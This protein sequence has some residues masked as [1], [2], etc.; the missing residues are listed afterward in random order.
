M[1]SLEE[2]IERVADAAFAQTSPVRWS[3]P[4]TPGHSAVRTDG[5]RSALLATAAVVLGLALIGG[6]LALARNDRDAP[7]TPVDSGIANV[8]AASTVEV[9]PSASAPAEP[10]TSTTDRA[11]EEA[12]STAP[13][14]PLRVVPF[15]SEVDGSV[16]FR[17]REAN[18]DSR[19][20]PL[21]DGEIVLSY[22]LQLGFDPK[23]RSSTIEQLSPISTDGQL[24]TAVTCAI[25]GCLAPEPVNDLYQTALQLTVRRTSEALTEGVHS[26]EFRVVFDDGTVLPFTVTQ[27]ANPEPSDAM[28]DV[29]AE[30]SGPPSQVQTV[31]APGGFPYHAISAFD[32]IWILDTAGGYVT[33]LDA[34]SG[35]VLATIDVEANGNRLAAADD[36]IYVSAAPAVRI[37]PATNEATTITGG[38]PALGIVSDGT[39]VWTA[40]FRRPIQRLDPDGTITTLDLPADRWMDLAVSNGMV[41]ALSQDPT[42]NDS[43]LIAFDSTTSEFRYDIAIPNEGNGAAVRLVAD[44]DS[45]V[46][47]AATSGLSARTGK[48]F[49]IDPTTGTIVDEV[50]LDS[51]PEGIVLTPNHI[52][53]SQAVLDRGTLEVLDEQHFGFTITRGPDGSIWGTGGSADGTFT[54]TR[55]APGD[56][57]D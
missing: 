1:L 20:P 8:T 50:A 16:G 40:G 12:A 36:A 45:V 57:D 17:V 2:Q 29:V 46:V 52:W 15:G 13:V 39:T 30:S 14:S 10:G 49:V 23:G 42:R 43:R 56:L 7:S 37:D 4:G 5:R 48:L 9:E 25:D 3:P 55:T 31:L 27:L 47:G 32:S 18:I 24:A 35:A 41:W 54:A 44:D 11:V 22:E 53:T 19:P 21:L 26:T 38:E 6:L 51:R 33:R 28:A 34:T